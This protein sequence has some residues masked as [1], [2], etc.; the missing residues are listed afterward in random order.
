MRSCLQEKPLKILFT[1]VLVHLESLCLPAGADVTSSSQRHDD[2]KLLRKLSEVI[3]KEHGDSRAPLEGDSFK[4]VLP[5]LDAEQQRGEG[6]ALRGEWRSNRV[7][8]RSRKTGVMETRAC[9]VY[10]ESSPG[11]WFSIKIDK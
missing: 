11:I 7:V 8:V 3:R 1:C 9:S 6:G 4:N 10:E 5:D 2:Q